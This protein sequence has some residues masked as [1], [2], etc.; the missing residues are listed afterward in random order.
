MNLFQTLGLKFIE[1]S[2]MGTPGACSFS[3]SLGLQFMHIRQIFPLGI[4]LSR[5]PSFLCWTLQKS[6][7]WKGHVPT[8]TWPIFL[9]LKGMKGHLL[10]FVMLLGHVPST[11]ERIGVLEPLSGSRH[12]HL[13]ESSCWVLIHL[14][15]KRGTGIPYEQMGP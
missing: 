8:I 12:S 2:F 15:I 6:C 13:C 14:S 11:G 5:V 10:E 9:L 3:M 4:F 1:Q 7:V